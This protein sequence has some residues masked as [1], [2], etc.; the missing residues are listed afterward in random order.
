MADELLDLGANAEEM[1][2]NRRETFWIAYLT[3]ERAD[4]KELGDVRDMVA[5]AKRPRARR[6]GTPRYKRQNGRRPDDPG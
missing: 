1:L 4:V 6:P 2:E 3:H 5:I